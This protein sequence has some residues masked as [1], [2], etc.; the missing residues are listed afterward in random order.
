MPGRQCQLK[1]QRPTDG[2]HTPS[3]KTLDTGTGLV[4]FP[5]F[6]QPIKGQI[7]LAATPAQPVRRL[8]LCLLV[9]QAVFASYLPGA[10]KERL[11]VMPRVSVLPTLLATALD[12]LLLSHTIILRTEVVRMFVLRCIVCLPRLL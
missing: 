12:L 4:F 6:L 11:P 10:Q 3:T 8:Q 1:Q 7:W 9:L 2:G 5:F